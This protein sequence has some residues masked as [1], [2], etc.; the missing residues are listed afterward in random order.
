MGEIYSRAERVIVWL[1][2]VSARLN[3]AMRELGENRLG[4]WPLNV[5]KQH[6]AGMIELYESTYWSRAW[7]VQEYLLAKTIT[8][9]C[10]TAQIDE[11]RLNAVAGSTRFGDWR[12]P[13]S[14]V[15]EARQRRVSRRQLVS[16]DWEAE[17]TELADDRTMLGLLTLFYLDMFCE[18]PRDRMYSLLS[19]LDTTERARLAITPDYSMST[20]DLFACVI[21]SFRMSRTTYRALAISA[22][23]EM[24]KLDPQDHVVTDA[25]RR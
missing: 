9:W 6:T 15:I 13:A 1:G 16:S 5:I 17:I 2:T 24:L 20:S 14:R 7:I 3:S 22:L 8:I 21:R 12:F 4:S 18:D 19:L 23:V 10:K 11:A 25:Q